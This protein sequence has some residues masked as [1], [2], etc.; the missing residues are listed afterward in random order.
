MTTQ[1]M[2][3]I[4]YIISYIQRTHKGKIETHDVTA[5]GEEGEDLLWRPSGAHVA[6]LDAPGEGGP[7]SEDELLSALNFA[8]GECSAVSL[9]PMT[10][11]L[12]NSE[13]SDPV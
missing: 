1:V 3:Y 8:K 7:T 13:T 4:I 5:A 11:A 9:V 6:E 12:S 10:P 2:I